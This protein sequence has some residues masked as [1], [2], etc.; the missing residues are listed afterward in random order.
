MTVATTR[1]AL[2]VDAKMM[3]DAASILDKY[4][5]AVHGSDSLE[6]TTEQ[7]AVAARMY[8]VEVGILQ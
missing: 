6:L 1:V 3:L 4:M 7:R 2:A 8:A 5:Q